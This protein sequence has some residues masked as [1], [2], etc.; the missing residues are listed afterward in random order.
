MVIIPVQA[1]V[2]HQMVAQEEAVLMAQQ[3]HQEVQETHPLQHLVREITEAAVH[4]QIPTI[5][6]VVA[7]AQEQ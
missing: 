6:V 4:T 3:M 2:R 7:A 1:Q 5:W